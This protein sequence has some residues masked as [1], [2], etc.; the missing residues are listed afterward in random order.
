MSESVAD[1]DG[2]CKCPPPMLQPQESTI[3]PAAFN[4]VR[5]LLC[6]CEKK[7]RKP[8]FG[9]PHNKRVGLPITPAFFRIEL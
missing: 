7:M 9:K 2:G 5:Q 1:A 8:W 3:R 4:F 6:V